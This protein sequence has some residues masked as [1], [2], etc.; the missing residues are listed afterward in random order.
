MAK[1]SFIISKTTV[2][3]SFTKNS[4]KPLIA[5]CSKNKLLS[6]NN[7]LNYFFLNAFLTLSKPSY[8]PSQTAKSGQFCLASFKS[9]GE[10]SH[11]KT[12]MHLSL[13]LLA[14][15]YLALIPNSKK[16][17]ENASSTILISP[18]QQPLTKYF[19]RP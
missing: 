9:I 8:P 10:I 14:K 3:P 16:Y 15:G 11:P 13:K 7:K 4:I 18:L 19:F 1:F 17:F 6:K 2:P 12:E 5:L